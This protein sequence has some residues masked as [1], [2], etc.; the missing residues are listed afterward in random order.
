M[1]ADAVL[2]GRTL[3]VGPQLVALGEE[4][5]PF[6][7]QLERV[8][9]EVVGRIDPAA[10]IEVFIPA[11]ADCRVL[12]DQ[13]E[14]NACLPQPDRGADARHARADDH[15]REVF[16]R[17]RFGA[18]APD[19]P[20]RIGLGGFEILAHHRGI[21]GTDM[22]ADRGREHV[23][24]EITLRQRRQ[25]TAGP[26]V[27]QQRIR[28]PLADF[29]AQV[30]GHRLVIVHRPG[31]V[32][33]SAFEQ[34]VIARQLHQH[35]HQR[36]GI[37]FGECCAQRSGIRRQCGQVHGIGPGHSCSLAPGAPFQRGQATLPQYH[38]PST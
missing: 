30:F 3:E 6:V 4:V 2:V 29:R 31:D 27:V 12:L 14:G 25:R 1:L 37:R 16:E 20:A 36:R 22:F 33:A 34:A 26:G 28:Q 18:L 13:R 9:I 24:Q 11:A 38:L 10:G 17:S 8:G 15:H 32:R 23:L 7:V 5:R 21:V 19:Q 35:E